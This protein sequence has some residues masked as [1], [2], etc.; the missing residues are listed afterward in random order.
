MRVEGWGAEAFDGEAFLRSAVPQAQSSDE[1]ALQE[2]NIPER[3]VLG[4]HANLPEPH[5]SNAAFPR[6]APASRRAGDSAPAR[7]KEIRQHIQ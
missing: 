3:M 2:H 5:L 1:G 6:V 7:L 4:D